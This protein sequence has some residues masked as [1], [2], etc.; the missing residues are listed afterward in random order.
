MSKTIAYSFAVLVGCSSAPRTP[1]QTCLDTAEKVASAAEHCGLDKRTTYANFIREAADGSCANVTSIR[2]E[3]ELRGQCFRWLEGP[4]TG[5]PALIYGQ[6]IDPSCEHQLV[7]GDA[8][9][10]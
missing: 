2:D 1:Q 10:D 3:A 9:R 8:G 6:M 4:C 5:P 7:R